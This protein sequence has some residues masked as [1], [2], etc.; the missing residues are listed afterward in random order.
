MEHNYV[1]SCMWEIHM[2]NNLNDAKELAVKIIREDVAVD[3]EFET[4]ADFCLYLARIY[5]M[6]KCRYQSNDT[7]TNITNGN[8]WSS[9]V[10]NC[11]ILSSYHEFYARMEITDRYVALEVGDYDECC[12]FVNIMVYITPISEVHKH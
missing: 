11:G 2:V 6:K 7:Y 4:P 1:V 8:A 9:A 3:G 10:V 12:E 5:E